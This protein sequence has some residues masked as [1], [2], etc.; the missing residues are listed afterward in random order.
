MSRP[1]NRMRPPSGAVS[2]VNCPSS[3]VLPAPLGPMIACNSPGASASEMPSEA[4]TPPKCLLRLSISSSA[5]ATASSR[6]Q[7]S[8]AAID[9]ERDEKQQ[10]PDDQI[11]IVGDARQRFFQQQKRHRPD[12]R[13]EHGVHAAEHGHHHE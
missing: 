13:P 10:R 5:S 6:D 3:V 7:P 9:V 8:D 12:Q 2:P 4:T 11:G 1:A